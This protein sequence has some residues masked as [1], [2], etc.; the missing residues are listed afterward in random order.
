MKRFHHTLLRDLVSNGAASLTEL[1]RRGVHYLDLAFDRYELESIVESA[2]RAGLVERLGEDVRSDGTPV[3]QPEWAPT[4]D[5]RSAVASFTSWLRRGA[6]L[7]PWAI[8]LGAVKP[9]F[10]KG[11]KY[12]V[13]GLAGAILVAIASMALIRRRVAG[14]SR[15]E[16]AREW[17][18]HATLLP[19]LNRHHGWWTRNDTITAIVLGG[20]GGGAFAAVA[21]WRSRPEWLVVLA[22]ALYGITLV[23]GY[24]MFFRQLFHQTARVDL[25]V[26]ARAWREESRTYE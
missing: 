17:S 9:L 10:D 4:A 6:T 23:W 12:G 8:L 22:V 20:F 21:L 11:A 15:R 18:R 13:A 7:L 26:E 2:R 14:A 25:E 1:E 19:L 5:G 16:V 3:T 24:L